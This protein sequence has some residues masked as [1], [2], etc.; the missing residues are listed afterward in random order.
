MLIPLELLLK[1]DFILRGLSPSWSDL[2]ETT[3]RMPLQIDF[4]YA[5]VE[6]DSSLARCA[7]Y[8]FQPGHQPVCQRHSRD[9]KALGLASA[10]F[11]I[12][13]VSQP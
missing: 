1:V 6:T 7:W 8:A 12:A 13:H 11:R 2:S 3:T 10:F 4:T 5:A 9:I